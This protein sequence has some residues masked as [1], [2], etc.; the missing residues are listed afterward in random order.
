MIMEQ[1][2]A[3][4]KIRIK[5]KWNGE[6]RF[7]MQACRFSIS[8]NTNSTDREIDKLHSKREKMFIFL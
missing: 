2:A 4:Q 6:K 7:F 3:S 5:E 8:K 1:T